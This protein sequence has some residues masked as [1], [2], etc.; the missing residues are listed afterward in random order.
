MLTSD[1]FAVFH[2]SLSRWL[3]CLALVFGV[4]GTAALAQDRTALEAAGQL[5]GLLDGAVRG[6]SGEDMMSVLEGAAA[7]GETLAM[8]QLGQMYENGVGVR[9]DSVRAFAYYSRIAN[10]NADA[11]PHSLEADIVAR[12]FVKVGDYY[13]VGL[14]DAGIDVDEDQ[15][16]AL[17][18]HAASYFGNAD[19]QY[20]VGLMYLQDE[21]VGPN[22]LLSAR[23]L[24][25]AAHKNHAAA[26]AVL[27]DLLFNG[28]EGMEPQP[29][30]GLMWLKLAQEATLGSDQEVWASELLTRAMLV[31][32]PEQREAALAAASSV[33]PRL[34]SR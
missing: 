7:A 20:R 13:R 18:F 29:V 31:A 33:R 14:P 2:L 24:S 17:L 26:Q 11:P 12:S 34:A 6:V 16:R 32:T 23:W 30:E 27:G 28:R 22:P 3:L 4:P 19:A 21:K 25:L 5:G 1:A 9:Q 10:D 15:A 8:W